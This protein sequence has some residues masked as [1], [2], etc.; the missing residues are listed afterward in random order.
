M[1]IIREGYDRVTEILAIFSS[2]AHVDKKR[3]KKAQDLGTSVHDAIEKFYR[4][5]FDPMGYLQNGYFESF[6]AWSAKNPVFPKVVEERFYDDTLMITGKVDLTT[7]CH[8][9]IDFKTGS[10]DHPEIWE[11]QAQFY[12]HLLNNSIE[13]C[14]IVKLHS[15]GSYPMVYTFYP[16][17]EKWEV[18]KHAIACYR[19][20]Y[21][22]KK[23]GVIIT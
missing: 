4:G 7:N 20:F 22:D 8:E 10:W 23:D 12:C 18:C 13:K 19:Y 16:S 14:Y 9:L 11:L 5:H 17:E 2:F 6:L 21:R 15:D 3:L 1:E